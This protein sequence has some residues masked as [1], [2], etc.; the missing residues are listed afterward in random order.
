MPS[1]IVT[2]NRTDKLKVLQINLQHCIAASAALLK[3]IV[4]GKVEVALVQEPYL[5]KGK[6]SGLNSATT[7]VFAIQNQGGCR[8]CIVCRKE[9]DAILL[10]QFSSGDTT[11]I[12]ILNPTKSMKQVNLASVYLPYDSVV[13]PTPE[14]Q[15]IADLAAVSETI[16]GCDA[17]SHHILWGSTDCNERGKLLV[18]FLSRTNLNIINKGTVPTFVTKSRREVLDIT[19]ATPGMT[20]MISNWMV[21]NAASLSDHRWISFGVSIIQTEE[22]TFKNPRSADWIT[23]TSATKKGISRLVKNRLRTKTDIDKQVNEVTKVIVASYEANC[24]TAYKRGSRVRWWTSEL[25]NMKQ[26]VKR[27]Y[28]W[29]VLSNQDLDWNE[30]RASLRDFKRIIRKEKRNSWSS[31]C[32]NLQGTNKT[33]NIMKALRSESVADSMLRREDGTWTES[34]DSRLKML[35]DH[36]FPDSDVPNPRG[37]S[38]LPQGRDARRTAKS[39]VDIDK[40]KWAVNSF[41]PYKA[42]GTDGV[43]PKMLQEA[44]ESLHRVLVNIFRASITKGYIPKAWRESK[45]VFI[46]KPG[47]PSHVTAK[48][49]RPIS[50]S[51]FLL[52]TLERLM[53]GYIKNSI[54]L[55]ELCPNQ[56]AYIAGRSVETALHRVV[57]KIE[58]SMKYKEFTL[59]AFLD[60]EGAFNNVK[61]ESLVSAVSSYGISSTVTN[62]IT[63]LLTKRNIVSAYKDVTIRG[64]IHKGTPQGGI[65]SPLVWVLTV[66]GIVEWLQRHGYTTVAYADDLVIMIT[67]KYPHT[68]TDLM[69]TA[70]KHLVKWAD[71][72]GLQIN[73]VK[74]ELVMFTR[75]RLPTD[76]RIPTVQGVQLKLAVQAKY[77][78]IILDS[79]LN[80]RAN[81][82]ERKR[83]AIIA[84]FTMKRLVYKNYGL[85]P[86]LAEWIFKG[87]VRP[88][89][90]Y[91]ALVW[92]PGLEKIT[93]HRELESIQRMACLSIS[94]ALGSTPTMGLYS[95]L[96]ILP[97][98]IF[99]KGEAYMAAIRVIKNLGVGRVTYGHLGLI[100]TCDQTPIDYQKKSLNF[101]RKYKIIT[102]DRN[103]WSIDYTQISGFENVYTDGSKM[104]NRVGAGVFVDNSQQH[105]QSFRLPDYATVFQAEIAAIKLAC[106]TTMNSERNLHIL[107]DSK[108]GLLALSSPYTKSQLVEECKARL[109]QAAGF[110]KV[111]LTWVPGHSGLEGNEKADELARN[112]TALSTPLAGIGKPLSAIRMENNNNMWTN[113]QIRWQSRT[114]CRVSRTIW[115]EVNQCKSKNLTNWSR[116][117]LRTL[118][119]AVTGHCLLRSHAKKMKVGMDVDCRMCGEEEETIEHFLID[120]PALIRMRYK[121]FGGIVTELAEIANLDI[122]DLA[123]FCMEAG[124][125]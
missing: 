108:A 84:L 2:M 51:S 54:R 34:T 20:D 50:L 22:I 99:I 106:E 18:D 64:D 10:P 118:I 57:S 123:A 1:H 100:S 5:N 17:N 48:D 67:G 125:F 107:S 110:K 60:I 92:W 90:A 113:F 97:I 101:V 3:Q 21:P 47:R 88:I 124:W 4:D 73:P 61:S 87:V 96:G 49:F 63:E 11:T 55:T 62:W 80:W 95:V 53:D 115:P 103:D 59:A 112:G 121:H 14:F 111:V 45:V 85:K 44:D 102:P 78:G 27:L 74:T 42:P 52:K 68:L 89:L 16:I 30:Y 28:K 122:A 33:A 29:A 37:E 119:G 81:I 71:R 35:I 93:Y 66:N 8:S 79:K 24:P 91:G 69:Q 116:K 32:E 109:N 58:T 72:N 56:H 38:R 40:V 105:G 19:L 39:I 117:K 77:L 82:L 43:I 120:C 9:I 12:K 13:H 83:K 6:V 31:F 7:R 98:D 114:D 76:L 94:G 26:N 25:N 46:P 15:K 86:K 23:Y 41:D 70:L 75:N 65:I 36:H 104:E